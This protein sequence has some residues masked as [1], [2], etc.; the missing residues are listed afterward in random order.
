MG[1]IPRKTKNKKIQG[2]PMNLNSYVK[3]LT[4]LQNVTAFGESVF[5][6]AVKFKQGH[7][8]APIQKD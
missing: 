1:P 6:E 8:V 2:L 4:A 5:K 7:I 3:V